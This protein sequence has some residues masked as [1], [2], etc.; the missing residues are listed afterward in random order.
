MTMRT[1]IDEFREL[2]DAHIRWKCDG[3]IPGRIDDRERELWVLND[4][5]L[6]LWALEEGVEGI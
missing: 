2:I 1:F 4:E 3:K 5:S 6:Y